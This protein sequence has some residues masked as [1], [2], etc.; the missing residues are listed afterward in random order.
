MQ[1][2]INFITL[3]S[4]LL[5]LPKV[6]LSNI[7]KQQDLDFLSNEDKEFYIKNC[8]LNNK[9]LP[10]LNCINYLGIRIFLNAI[11]N[12]KLTKEELKNIENTAISYLTFASENGFTDSFIN[13]G[14]IFSNRK[15]NFYD[16]EKS[17]KYYNSANLDFT[18]NKYNERSKTFAPSIRQFL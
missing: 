6:L 13:L 4:F 5:V 7:V 11:N 10:K 15:S 9:P 16:L 8:F 17:A 18:E 1:S 2:I 14:W 3:L 12:E